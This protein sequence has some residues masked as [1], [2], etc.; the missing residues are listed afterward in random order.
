MSFSLSLLHHSGNAAWRKAGRPSVDHKVRPQKSGRPIQ[1]KK[2]A[3]R[4]TNRGSVSTCM[5]FVSRA[6]YP[7]PVYLPDVTAAKTIHRAAS[8]EAPGP[9]FPCFCFWA[10]GRRVRQIIATQGS[11]ARRQQNA[12]QHQK[13][14]S[15]KAR[16]QCDHTKRVFNAL[17]RH[18]SGI[19]QIWASSGRLILR[20]IKSRQHSLCPDVASGTRAAMVSG[21]DFDRDQSKTPRPHV[22]NA[23]SG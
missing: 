16:I 23:A 2:R 4:A 19:G 8:G 10:G 21:H 12:I 17:F 6:K 15:S 22:G 5:D 3:S 1:Q 14:A 13:S 20:A 11:K 9:V 18:C 7:L